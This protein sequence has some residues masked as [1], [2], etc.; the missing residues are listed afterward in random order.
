MAWERLTDC[1]WAVIELYAE[2]EDGQVRDD[3]ALGCVS[4]KVREVFTE[5]YLQH[6]YEKA[7]LA[8]DLAH[9]VRKIE[10]YDKVG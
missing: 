9:R 1:E 4:G 5:G 6:L 8:L 7:T 10:E 3:R 2:A